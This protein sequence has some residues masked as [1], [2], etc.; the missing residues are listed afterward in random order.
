MTPSQRA[1]AIRNLQ[2][3]IARGRKRHG[4]VRE[5]RH[6]LIRLVAQHI[7]WECKEDRKEGVS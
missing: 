7:R 5:R 1:K 2:L 4:P 3:D 6:K